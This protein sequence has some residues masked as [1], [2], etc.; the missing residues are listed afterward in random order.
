MIIIKARRKGK[1]LPETGYENRYVVIFRAVIGEDASFNPMDYVTRSEKFAKEH[2]DHNAGMG[3]DSSVVRAMVKA[4][5]V[6]EAYN[7][8]EYFY[9]G[10]PVSGKVIYSVEGEEW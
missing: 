7:P 2:A 8:G 3:D 6:Y 5:D 4:E 10:P 1:S 9:D